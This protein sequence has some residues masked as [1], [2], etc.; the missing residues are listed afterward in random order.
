M[1]SQ[2]LDGSIL[3][4]YGYK[5][6]KVK[7]KLTS[8]ELKEYTVTKN[9]FNVINLEVVD[10]KILSDLYVYL[11]KHSEYGYSDIRIVDWKPETKVLVIESY[12]N[13]ISKLTYGI[14]DFYE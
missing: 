14:D 1:S 3:K 9:P 7:L 13:K 10:D 8:G 5:T 12:N 11:W 6:N 4:E 2:K